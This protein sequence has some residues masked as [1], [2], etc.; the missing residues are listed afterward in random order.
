M[1]PANLPPV[2][3]PEVS[4]AIERLIDYQG[5]SYA[6]LY[7]DRL[8]AL[9]RRPGV[10]AVMLEEIAGLMVM[11][12]SYAGSDP[13]RA[14]KLVESETGLSCARQPGGDSGNSGSMS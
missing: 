3:V 5:P 2:L 10:D 9:R 1:P 14:L 4:A 6:Q 12:M 11:R 8:Q 7:V 13:D